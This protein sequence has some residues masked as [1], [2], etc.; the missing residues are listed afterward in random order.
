MPITVSTRSIGKRRALLGDF[1]VGPPE[2]LRD[3]GGLTLRELIEHIVRC[4]VRAYQERQESA[5]FDRVLSAAE[6]DRGAAAGKVDPAG[7]APVEAPDPIAAVESAL[8]AF[9]DGLYLVVIDGVERRRL[10]EPVYLSP[11]SSIV[12][13]RLTF[14][15]GA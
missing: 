5:R 8:Q 6:I 1:E 11:S 13:L 3:D 14:L 15:A 2:D 9:E 10:S 4:Q 12:F 7:K